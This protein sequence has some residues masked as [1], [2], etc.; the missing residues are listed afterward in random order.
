MQ[1]VFFSKQILIPGSTNYVDTLSSGLSSPNSS[2]FNSSN[3]PFDTARR[4]AVSSTAA[5]TSAL[6]VTIVG[7]QQGGTP[8]T[9]SV[10][11][12]SAGA[13]AAAIG[14]GDFL[15]VSSI[16]TSSVANVQV[17]IGTSSVASTPWKVAG[18][19]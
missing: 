9:E 14:R 10:R 4:V 15:T 17:L 3:I 5:D 7:T 19:D 16:T 11:G 12:S 6:L 18:I 13:G 8:Y 2:Q 1:P